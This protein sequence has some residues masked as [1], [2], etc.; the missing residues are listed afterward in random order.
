LSAPEPKVAILEPATKRAIAFID[1]QN[2]YH[3]AKAAFD[4]SHPNYDVLAL[5]RTICQ[6]KGW[7]FKAARFYTG[8]PE[9]ADDPL[10]HNFWAK[11][12]LAIKRQG[13]H[14]FSRRLRYRETEVKIGDEVHTIMVGEEKGIDIRIALDCV[15]LSLSNDLDVAVIFSQD[16]DMSEVVDEIKKIARLQKRWIKA[17]CAYPLS[18]TASNRRGING[19]EWVSFDKALYDRCTDPHDYR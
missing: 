6:S 3:H 9:L 2:L 5:A 15:S 19:S 18:P 13:V 10:W 14:V 1:G 7:F 11:K 8:T 4:I 17:A 12:L 16:Q